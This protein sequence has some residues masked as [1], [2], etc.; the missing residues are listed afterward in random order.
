[1]AK[2]TVTMPTVCAAAVITWHKSSGAYGCTRY[3]EN[4]RKKRKM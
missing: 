2:Q 1:M 4:Y 3:T